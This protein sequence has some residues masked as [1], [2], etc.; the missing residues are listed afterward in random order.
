MG[1][2]RFPTAGSFPYTLLIPSGRV[3]AKDWG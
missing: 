2:D 1:L 3:C